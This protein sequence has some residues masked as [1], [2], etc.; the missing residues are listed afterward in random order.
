M[1]IFNE[2]ISLKVD[3]LIVE[4]KSGELFS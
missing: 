3:K 1:S 2:E 4:R